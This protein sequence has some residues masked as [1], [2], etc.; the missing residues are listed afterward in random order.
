MIPDFETIMNPLLQELADGN[1]REFN[2]SV[3]SLADF[4]NLTEEERKEML[5]SGTQQIFK[6]RIGW[7]RT[8]LKK[9]ELIVSVGRGIVKISDRGLK[10]IQDGAI[11]NVNY[12]KQ[13][14]EFNSFQTVRKDNNGHSEQVIDNSIITVNQTPEESIEIG[15]RQLRS[16]LSQELL[17]KISSMSFSF[18]EKLVVEVLVKMGYGGSLQDA[19]RVIGKT[20]DEGIDGTIKEDKLGLDVIYIQAKRWQNVVGRPEIQKFVGAL[21]GQGARKG[22][23][24]TTSSFTADA[25][26][27]TP[28]NETKIVLID[29]EQ[30]A[31]MM[32]DHNVGVSLQNAYEIKRIDNDYFDEN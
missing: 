15:Y 32:I 5:P 11:V 23:F 19:G 30:L 13:Y 2:A 16:E 17:E 9:A 24:I 14:P 31:Q 26:A 25:K 27:Y 21:A 3:E 28:K 29:G 22:V 8:Y 7:A 20:G 10:A 18:F 1:S 12:L 4:F 6:N